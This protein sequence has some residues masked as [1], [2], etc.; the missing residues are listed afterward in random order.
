MTLINTYVI[1]RNGHGRAMLQHK[2]IDGSIITLCGRDMS[3]W[4]RT[5]MHEPL[6]VILCKRCSG[7]QDTK[8]ETI[9]VLQDDGTPVNG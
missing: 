5:Y 7:D 6:P 3:E 2:L 9:S 1:A 4:S 8:V